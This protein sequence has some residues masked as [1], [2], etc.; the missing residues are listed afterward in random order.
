MFIFLDNWISNEQRLL[1]T[2]KSLYPNNKP[3]RL[4]SVYWINL[5]SVL[6]DGLC[7]GLLFIS[8]PGICGGTRSR[9][10]QM[11]HKPGPETALAR[12][13]ARHSDVSIM[14][15]GDQGRVNCATDYTWCIMCRTNTY[16]HVPIHSRGPFSPPGTDR[17]L[18]GSS[19][20]R[21]L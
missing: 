7:R 3:N 4:S 19:T 12:S 8:E 11:D 14:P 9:G 21:S 10:S 13:A 17:T 2:T 15:A 5:F 1:L 6:G 16:K 18:H 20:Q